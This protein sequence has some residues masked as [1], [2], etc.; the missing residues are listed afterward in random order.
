M[1]KEAGFPIMNCLSLKENAKKALN[2]RDL[3]TVLSQFCAARQENRRDGVARLPEFRRISDQAVKMKNRVLEHIDFY[4]ETF[5]KN[6]RNAGGQVHWAGTD[7]AA[8][9]IIGDICKGA[10]A[11]KVVKGKSMVTEEIG[12]NAHLNRQGIDVLET[13]LGE[14]IV[15]L[16]DE[17]P[18]HIIGPAIHVSA[19]QVAETF[20]RKHTHLE[21]ERNMEDPAAMVR[22]ARKVLRAHFLSADVGITGANFLVAETGSALIVT[23]EGNAD[24]SQTLPGTHIVV[25]GIEKVVPGLDDAAMLLRLLPRSVTGQET[26]VYT[27]IATGPKRE[28]DMDGPENFHVVLVDNGRSKAFGTP[29]QAM[30]R[31]IRCSA[32]MNHCP[33][34]GA[35]GGHA[36]GWIYP[37]PMGQVLTP[38]LKGLENAIYHPDACSLCGRCEEVCPMGIPLPDLLRCFREVLA[39][40]KLDATAA[41]WGGKLWASMAT[42]PRLYRHLMAGISMILRMTSKLP[43]P[44]VGGRKPPLPEGKTFQ[45]LWSK[46]TK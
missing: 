10:N 40:R 21:P 4:L 44:K 33:V 37:G 14:Y 18:S 32:C 1:E 2:N 38:L 12:L 31:C 46:E 22:E 36:F 11:R 8:C 13:D 19:A 25:A 3:Q 17:T 30:L 39:E 23:N 41:R 43:I 35:I 5:D 9:G 24:L 26:A 20:R 27:T 6:V 45:Q 34:Y 29:F 42:H 28:G 15:Q 7:E 16:R